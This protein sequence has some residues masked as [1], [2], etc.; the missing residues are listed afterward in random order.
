MLARPGTYAL[1]L[2]SS[3]D[4]WITVGKLG[5]LRVR[6]G[7]YVYVG[8]AFG[9]GG[10]KARIAHHLK[11]SERPH[12]HIDYLRPSTDP[13]E[14]WFTYDARHREHQ[15]A[16]LLASVSRGSIPIT[17]F[18]ASDCRCPSHLFF[19][20]SQPSGVVIRRRL[21]ATLSPQGKIF[22]KKFLDKIKVSDIH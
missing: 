16:S 14:I 8:S 3:S 18:G 20:N 21:H 10:L 2:K 15:W 12:W 19:F 5:R 17:A 6:P 7:F 13:T 9:P 22:A 1:V 4:K 11:I